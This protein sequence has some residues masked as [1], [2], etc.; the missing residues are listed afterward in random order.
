MPDQLGS[1]R[2]VLDATTGTR[3]ASYDFTPYGAVTQSSVTNGTDYQYAG[4]FKHTASG[5]NL[6]TT[7][8]HDGVTG[9]W[10][11]RDP[12]R[13]IGGMNLYTYGANPINGVDPFGLWQWN[14][15]IGLPFGTSFNFTFGYNSGQL[16][17]GAYG[18]IGGGYSATY[19][20]SDTGCKNT[21]IDGGLKTAGQVGV[22]LGGVKVGGG[23][24][25]DLTFGGSASV[26]STINV[27]PIGSFGG[28]VSST[29]AN[30]QPIYTPISRARVPLSQIYGGGASYFNGVGGTVTWN[31]SGSNCGCN[32]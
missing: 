2:D 13:E 15:T 24:G 25:G 17:V 23:L 18:G 19:D 1:V 3:V 5:L 16:N 4:L 22:N 6:S 12:I 21:G 11:N 20:G 8:A 28:R 31:G 26:Q 29:A 32:K 14:I 27:P 7:R 9:R 10:L 30:P